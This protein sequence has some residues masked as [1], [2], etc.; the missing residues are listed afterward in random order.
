MEYINRFFSNVKTFFG[1]KNDINGADASYMLLDRPTVETMKQIGSC[2][3]YEKLTEDDFQRYA[4]GQLNTILIFRGLK[5]K[6]MSNEF[7]DKVFSV[8][9]E[10]GKNGIFHLVYGVN[11]T[12]CIRF[13]YTLK[14]DDID[15]ISELKNIT[16]YI[17]NMKSAGADVVEVVDM[18]SVIDNDSSF[19]PSIER[20]YVIMF[21]VKDEE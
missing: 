17:A 21:T 4:D 14:G 19:P 5:Y 13:F 11:D 18:G 1:N 9:R 2:I 3:L 7:I 16:K 12:N 20:E 10:I 6:K 15:S 8:V